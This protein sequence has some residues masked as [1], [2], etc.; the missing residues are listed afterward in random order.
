MQELINLWRELYFH[1]KYYERFIA[2]RK[3]IRLMADLQKQRICAINFVSLNP[4]ASKKLHKQNDFYLIFIGKFRIVLK[5]F[6]VT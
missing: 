4:E 2:K 3:E 1:P 6:D 5:R